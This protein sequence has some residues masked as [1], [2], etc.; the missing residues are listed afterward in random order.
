MP[1]ARERDRGSIVFAG[2]CLAF[3]SALLSPALFASPQGA[4]VL[5]I[6]P[7]GADLAGVDRARKAVP[8]S[9]TALL[10]AGSDRV[11]VKGGLEVLVDVSLAKAPTADLVVLLAGEP[12]SAE[13]AFLLERKK[14][15][16]ALLLL[17][18]SPL[19]EKLRGTAG[20]ALI[21]VGGSDAIPAVLEAIGASAG[22]ELP[23]P[24]PAP[25]AAPP[26]RAVSATPAATPTRAATG[27]V[28]ERYFSSAPATPTP[29][30]R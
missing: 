5:L 10:V 7:P 12:G 3:S 1:S 21:L 14:T 2:L 20:S 18:G 11:R 26:A 28:F 22:A 19:A 27:R 13:E 8:P 29:S 24:R 30:P 23:E 17:P 15:A 4:R 16:R 6:V 9:Q 25:A